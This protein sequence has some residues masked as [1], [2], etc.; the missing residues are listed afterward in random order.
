MDV[1]V[2]F[3]LVWLG[4]GIVMRV[5][6]LVFLLAIKNDR[7][8]DTKLLYIVV[9]DPLLNFDGKI[10]ETLVSCCLWSLD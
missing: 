10:G 6:Y 3:L 8:S 7:D 9:L 5:A 4:L 1:S 2:L